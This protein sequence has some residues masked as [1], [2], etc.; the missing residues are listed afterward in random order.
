MD[1]NV[2][3]CVLIAGAFAALSVGNV[4]QVWASGANASEVMQQAKKQI[5]GKVV[6]ATGETLLVLMSLKKVQQTES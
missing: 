1:K 6:D 2:R 3:K 4:Q 5:K